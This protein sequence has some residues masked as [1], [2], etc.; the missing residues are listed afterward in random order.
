MRMLFGI[1]TMVLLVSSCSTFYQPKTVYTPTVD[2]TRKSEI[3]LIGGFD[4][5][6]VQGAKLLSKQKIAFFEFSYDYNELGTVNKFKDLITDNFYFGLGLGIR[7]KDQMSKHFIST[8]I[9]YSNRKNIN[10]GMGSPWSEGESRLIIYNANQYN[11]RLLYSYSINRENHLQLTPFFDLCYAPKLSF[12]STVSDWVWNETWG[13]TI[14]PHELF[15]G[16]F[17]IQSTIYPNR[18]MQASFGMKFRTFYKTN[19]YTKSFIGP[20]SEERFK[21]DYYDV[22]TSEFIYARAI[23]W[24][25]FR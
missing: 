24:L 4:A 17:G 2:S 7:P 22:F 16:I 10:L 12:Q 18:Y 21:D 3:K 9:G 23:I 25:R 13:Y 5:I 15:Y 8:S 14:S 20:G 1:L 19:T 6:E 11:F